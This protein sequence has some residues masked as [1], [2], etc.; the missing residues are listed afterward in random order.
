MALSLVVQCAERIDFWIYPIPNPKTVRLHSR[1]QLHPSV[2]P[3][4]GFTGFYWR[5]GHYFVPQ[6][7]VQGINK[8][9]DTCESVAWLLQPH[10]EGWSLSVAYLTPI[11]KNHQIWFA[12]HIRVDSSVAVPLKTWG[13]NLT[14]V[15]ESICLCHL[16]LMPSVGH[17]Q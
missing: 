10:R 12:Y 16:T 13:E 9:S 14:Q 7:R 17:W 3:I 11:N 5:P 15:E 2:S 6:L 4:A 1:T 8:Q